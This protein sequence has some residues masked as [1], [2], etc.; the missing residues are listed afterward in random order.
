MTANGMKARSAAR[1]HNGAMQRLTTEQKRRTNRV[2]STGECPM[3]K[4][5]QYPLSVARFRP[6]R[7]PVHTFPVRD[8]LTGRANQRNSYFRRRCGKPSAL[9]RVYATQPLQYIYIHAQLDTE[10]ATPRSHGTLWMDFADRR[11]PWPNTEPIANM[12]RWNHDGTCLGRAT[13]DF[14]GAR[15]PAGVTGGSFGND[16]APIQRFP[17]GAVDRRL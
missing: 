5:M 15:S 17:V 8:G 14:A 4:R 7:L 12:A 16:G 2:A 3:Q 11:R 9:Q 6:M 1:P 13:V 10:H